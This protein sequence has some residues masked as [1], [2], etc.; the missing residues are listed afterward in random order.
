[1]RGLAFRRHQW[2]RAKSRAARYLRWLSSSFSSDPETITTIQ[3]ARYAVDR[4]PCS[5]A[6]CGNP[7]RFYGEVTRQELRASGHRDDLDVLGGDAADSPIA[8]RST[9]QRTD[10]KGVS[11]ES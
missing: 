9:P 8:G 4:K 10:P 3:V 2:Q 1:M 5:C 6:M 7:R 11:G